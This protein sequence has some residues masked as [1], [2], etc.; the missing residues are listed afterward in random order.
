MASKFEAV[1]VT[2][3]NLANMMKAVDVLTRNSV[4]VGVIGF[5]PKD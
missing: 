5:D 1:T 2:A 4:F 3:D